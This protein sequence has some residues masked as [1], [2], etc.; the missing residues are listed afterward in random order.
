METP[1]LALQRSLPPFAYVLYSLA[2]ALILGLGT[3]Y[4]SVRGTYPLGRTQA[5]GW[6]A[7]PKLGARDVDPY[8]RAILARTGDIPL[9]LGEGIALLAEVDSDG[10]ALDAACRYR[11]AGITPVAR[12]WTLTLYG[13]DG[14]PVRTELERSGFTSAEVVRDLEGRFEVVLSRMPEPGNWLQTPA[15][16]R[17]RAILR[18][19]DTPVAGSLSWLDPGSLPIVRREGC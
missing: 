13:P 16:G 18:L 3:A 5:Q 8:A 17:L 11:I 15:G 4:W 9:G 6:V 12:Y 1:V 2:L 14:R 7:F 10:R 19:Y